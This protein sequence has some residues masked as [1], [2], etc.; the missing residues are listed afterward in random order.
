MVDRI[1]SGSRPVVHVEPLAPTPS[2]ADPRQEAFDR[3]REMAIG[4]RLQGEILARL[5]DGSFVVRMANSPDDKGPGA[6]PGGA[7]ARMRLPAS[8]QVGTF[9]DLTLVAK[10]PRLT[11]QLAP[12]KS[13]SPARQSDAAPTVLSSAGR[14][15]GKLLHTARQD[16]APAALVGKAPLV[17]S[18]TVEVRQIATALENTLV[19]SGL[20]YE[21]HVG[22]WAAG[23]RPLAELLREP[24]NQ[25]ANTLATVAGS[26]AAPVSGELPA[27]QPT[28][29]PTTSQP[30]SESA[31][32]P[33]SQSPLQPSSAP[34]AQ[35]HDGAPTPTQN[36]VAQDV[37]LEGAAKQLVAASA[38]QGHHEPD[39]AA[40]LPMPGP[41]SAR[42]INLQLDALEQRRV[43]WQGELWP[44]QPL[45]WEVSEQ[46]PENDAGEQPTPSW[47][48]TVHFSL[49]T[50]GAVSATIRLAAGHVQ[51]Q[52]RTA[53]DAA[54]HSLRLHG[55]ELGASLEAAGLPLDGLL[56]K[57]NAPD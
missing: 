30:T 32:E 42:L 17:A 35:G 19:R 24:Q 39:A 22:Q 18:P 48:S 33:A 8:A 23:A 4:K 26:A 20:F 10:Q 25:A 14:L 7:T 47:Q 31:S 50:L 36:N 57:Q 40:Q 3:L 5:N 45:S 43:L 12:S 16:K 38:A 55:A 54:A 2:V 44:G 9:V 37:Q 13:S 34:G 28:P 46:A 53:T 49:P 51:V 29:G 11:F 6:G 1:T 52:V 15:I 27:S 21:S 41:E 56:V